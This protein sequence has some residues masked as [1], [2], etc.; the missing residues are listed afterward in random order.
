SEAV[1]GIVEDIGFLERFLKVR[2]ELGA[3]KD[4]GII[5]DPEGLAGPEIFTYESLLAHEPADLEA[6]AAN[7]TPEQLATIIYTSGT[8]GPPKGVM[9]THNNI[10]WTVE[11]LKQCI[12]YDDYVGKR[13]VSYLP[14]AHIAE[15]MTSHYQGAFVGYEIT[16]CPDPGLLA[17]YLKEVHP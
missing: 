14:M 5:D 12:Q 2:G 9:L 3:L 11:S 13:L 16:C 8:T 15:R 4:L 17:G 10:A 1:L 7:C 6:A